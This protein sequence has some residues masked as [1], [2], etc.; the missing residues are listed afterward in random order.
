MKIVVK[1][2]IDKDNYMDRDKDKP[3]NV[4]EVGECGKMSENV[5]ECRYSL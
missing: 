1:I 2:D 4:G 3:K 5:R